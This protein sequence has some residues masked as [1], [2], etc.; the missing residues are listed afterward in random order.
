MSP[1]QIIV[2]IIII[3]SYE[4][5]LHLSFYLKAE[6]RY[7]RFEFLAAILAA[8]LKNMQLLLLFRIY[9]NSTFFISYES[10]LYLSVYLNAELRYIRFRFL[11][12]ILAAILNFF[13]LLI[14]DVAQQYFTN[15]KSLKSDYYFH[16]ISYLNEVILV[17]R[18]GC[19]IG[20][21][22]EK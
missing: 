16:C 13:I 7:I 11:A 4:S 15:R 18:I 3:I 14:L 12:A 10:T 19:H 22:L 2:I 6:L 8:I 9:L 20:R 21:H 5:T 1:H 17:S